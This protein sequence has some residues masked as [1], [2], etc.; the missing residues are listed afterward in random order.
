[1]LLVPAGLP[2]PE[3][4]EA[5]AN[6][7]GSPG[8][9]P[10]TGSA[11]T[12]TGG[13][14]NVEQGTGLVDGVHA[15]WTPYTL[16]ERRQALPAGGDIFLSRVRG[17]TGVR[18]QVSSEGV[19]VSDAYASDKAW[20]LRW[21]EVAA[22]LYDASG[23]M[24]MVATLG[25][26]VEVRAQ[27]WTP[28]VLDSV[29]RHA[30]SDL[31]RSVPVTAAPGAAAGGVPLQ[32][33]LKRR[34]LAFRSVGA[35]LLTAAVLLAVGGINRVRVAPEETGGSVA[36]ALTLVLAAGVAGGGCWVL[37]SARRIT[38]RGG[39]QEGE[40]RKR[41]RVEF[42]LEGAITRCGTRRLRV[43]LW[44]VSVVAILSVR[45][46]EQLLFPLAFGLLVAWR[47]ILELRLRARHPA[48]ATRL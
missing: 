36:F 6:E 18:L 41:G 32:G 24:I 13:S 45:L 47:C 35:L 33:D 7:G 4:L 5:V 8:A 46:F 29:R 30:P 23:T 48:G 17:D 43:T 31:L 1:M 28:G 26:S 15:G 21:S 38:E 22:V 25:G 16:P 11:V 44:V 20:T 40:F 2:Q 14:M 37:C 3:G 34:R 39:R 10:T 27:R 9:A 12:F 42:T 19:C